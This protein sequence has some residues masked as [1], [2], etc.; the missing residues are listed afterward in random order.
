[1]QVTCWGSAFRDAAQ[2]GGVPPWRRIAML[3]LHLAEQQC[4]TT[5]LV[6]AGHALVATEMLQVLLWCM[7]LMLYVYSSSLNAAKLYRVRFA[8]KSCISWTAQLCLCKQVCATLLSWTGVAAV[9]K[10]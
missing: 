10:V 2:R 5:K 3:T 1:M 8:C 9:L 7:R 6:E 4:R